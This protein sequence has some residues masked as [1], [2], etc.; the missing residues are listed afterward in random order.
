MHTESM[1]QPAEYVWLPV[2]DGAT[3]EPSPAGAEGIRT[4]SLGR[5]VA[6]GA[7]ISTATWTKAGPGAGAEAPRSTPR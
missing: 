7:S 3:P 4:L 2:L 5:H 1:L 6:S